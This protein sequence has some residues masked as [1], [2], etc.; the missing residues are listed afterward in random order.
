MQESAAQMALTKTWVPDEVRL[1]IVKGYKV[2]DILEV[3]E[4]KMTH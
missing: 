4:Y 2:L 1:A 3:C